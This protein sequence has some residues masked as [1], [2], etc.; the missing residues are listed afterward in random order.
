MTIDKAHGSL[1]VGAQLAPLA[2]QAAH[3]ED[4]NA[5]PTF[6]PDHPGGA[7][8]PSCARSRARRL[9]E[10]LDVDA[11]L[12]AVQSLPIRRHLGEHLSL[13][14]RLLVDQDRTHEEDLHLLQ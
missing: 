2:H 9:D 10:A 4:L 8:Q 5:E 12:L 7:D 11:C 13:L 6:H 14:V 1:S 3:G